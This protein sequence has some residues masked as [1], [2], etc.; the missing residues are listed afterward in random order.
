MIDTV[1]FDVGRVLVDFDWTERFHSLGYDDTM[2]KRLESCL[3]QSPIWDEFDRSAVPDEE[4]SEQFIAGDPECADQ[5]REIFGHV[6]LLIKLYPHTMEWIR[7]LK[8]RGYNVY[9]LSNYARSTFDKSPQVFDFLKLV[10][11]AL[12]SFECHYIKPEPD[13]YQELL[14]RFPI[15]AEHAVFIDDKPENLEAAQK[16]GIHTLQFTKYEET[17]VKLEQL[18]AE[19]TV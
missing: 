12:F 10:D 14:R 9:I 8:E 2:Q 4:L 11:G 6:E 5:I 15:T 13:I 3:F 16:F 18:L 1:I 7:G 19:S 17:S